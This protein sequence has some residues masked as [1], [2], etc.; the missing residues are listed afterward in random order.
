M[1]EP[2]RNNANTDA[3]PTA[4]GGN[5]KNDA[6]PPTKNVLVLAL[7][8][9]ALRYG[10]ATDNTPKKLPAYV[11]FPRNPNCNHPNSKPVRPY[12]TPPPSVTEEF[13]ARCDDVARKLE[14]DERRIGGGRPIPWEVECELNCVGSENAKSN[15]TPTPQRDAN[16]L[17]GRDALDVL[18]DERAEF[19]DVVAP[20]WDGK[21]VFGITQASDVL[22]KAAFAQLIK[23]IATEVY[24]NKSSKTANDNKHDHA[25][26]N[27]IANGTTANGKSS[28]SDEEPM[29]K[30]KETND[31]PRYVAMVIPDTSDRSDVAEFV[32]TIFHC[33]QLRAGAVFLHQSSVSCALGAGLAT[34]TVVDVGH[35]ATTIACV[36]EGTI[37]SESRA[38]L[39]YGANSMHAA[40]HHLLSE[41]SQFKQVIETL[42]VHEARHIAARAAEQVCTFKTDENDR[43]ASATVQ[44][45][46]TS[47]NTSGSVRI[48][49]GLALRI[50]PAHGLLE[51]KL[52]ESVAGE[53]LPK[54]PTTVRNTPDDTF[55]DRLHKE[56]KRNSTAS[57]AV[58]IGTFAA[59]LDVSLV[60]AVLSA[61]VRATQ[62]TP[63]TNSTVAR[64]LAAVVL[65]GGGASLDGIALALERRLKALATA[66]GVALNDVTVIDG[67]K[68]KGDEELAAATALL[69]RRAGKERVETPID[70]TDTASLPWKGGAVMVES[71]AVKEYWVLRNEWLERGV[72]VLRE[73][74]PFYW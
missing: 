35:S 42:G 7:G 44:I 69:A 72:R 58:P 51:P 64:F 12:A 39:R 21:L 57:A 40:F 43:L 38:H 13:R 66:R 48:K 2:N 63:T 14:L 19:Y 18:E 16:I 41:S 50:L 27:G 26:S 52:L 24:G 34:C 54:R 20:I 22:V 10:R 60:D 68:G 30:P 46:S 74:V 29:S 32:H 65:S 49:C 17:V 59:A 15:P 9:H 23:H 45:R 47:T 62:V 11:A 5:I 28:P 55:L 25:T 73:K 3:T 71:D 67:G 1:P 70:D 56:I 33:K 8:S 36:E 37:S 31:V 61:A 6:K 53:K 4:N